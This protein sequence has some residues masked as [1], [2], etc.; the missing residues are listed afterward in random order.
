VCNSVARGSKTEYLTEYVKHS[1]SNKSE[2]T[3]FYYGFAHDNSD[4]NTETN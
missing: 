4:V 3:Y 2:C 1:F